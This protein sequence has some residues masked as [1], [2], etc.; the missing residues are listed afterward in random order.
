[1]TL[2]LA[3]TLSTA[4]TQNKNPNAGKKTEKTATKST[5]DQLV[6]RATNGDAQAMLL[7]GK[8][9]YGGLEGAP[10]DYKTAAKWF[11]DAA[12]VDAPRRCNT[13]PRLKGG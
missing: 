1:M 5:L 11:L 2:A 13:A 3:V 12:E 10:K 9:Y 8:A 4:S 6:E 7:L